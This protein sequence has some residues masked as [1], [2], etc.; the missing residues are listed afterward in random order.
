MTNSGKKSFDRLV[1]I[2][3]RDGN[4]SNDEKLLID[5]I[6]S[7][8]DEYNQL[9]EDALKDNII[10]EKERALLMKR[11]S[12]FWG[13]AKNIALADKSVSK[14]ERALLEHL[15]EIIKELAMVEKSK[16]RN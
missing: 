12:K 8:V 3:L 6:T 11:R 9:L 7:D 5:R 13:D 1:E 14:E 10:D 2:A 16:T 4:I 15:V